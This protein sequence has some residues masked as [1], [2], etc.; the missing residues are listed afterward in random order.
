MTAPR[1]SAPSRSIASPTMTV[2][3]ATFAGSVGSRPTPART[4]C[5]VRA[6]A[7]VSVVTMRT[8]RAVSDPTIAGTTPA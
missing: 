7:L 3:V 2:R 5:D 1:R 8:V 6:I 4:L